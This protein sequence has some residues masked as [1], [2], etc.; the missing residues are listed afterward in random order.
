MVIYS[1]GSQK[2]L[3]QKFKYGEGMIFTDRISWVLAWKHYLSYVP[4]V[5]YVMD[6]NTSE[7]LIM[8]PYIGYQFEF[9][10][11]VPFWKGIMVIHANGEIEDLSPK[12]A[13]AD[14]RFKNQRLYPEKLARYIGDAWQYKNGIWNTV[15]LVGKHQNQ[16]VL[17][18]VSGDVGNKMPY[19]M[20]SGKGV[21]W[22]S[23]FKPYGESESIYKIMYIDAHNGSIAMYDIPA[24][25]NLGGPSRA[26]SYVKTKFLQY[27]WENQA[28][29]IEPRPV[30]VD[31]VIYYQ[32]SIT[33]KAF[34]GL[35]S[36]VLVDSN[37]NLNDNKQVLEFATYGELRAF[38]DGSHQWQDKKA[39]N[40]TKMSNQ[41]SDESL[42]NEAIA[43]LMEYKSRHSA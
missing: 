43:L 27:D 2:I 40:V 34:N 19:L 24:E 42:L 17:A 38:L 29:A 15:G 25:K 32:I 12:E 31:N 7:L 1:N 11:M 41:E 6:E 14:A 28:A 36:T 10:V 23:V 18:D 21:S 35:Q 22:V 8:A 39:E 33:N 26:V 4:D 13:I 3:E 9:P 16:A 5:Y 37:I 20:P 30:V